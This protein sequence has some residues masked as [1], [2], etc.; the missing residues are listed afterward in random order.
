MLWQQPPRR[1]RLVL[2]DLITWMLS[3][4]D[5]ETLM[6]ET[7]GRYSVDLSPALS[8]Q[9]FLINSAV[10]LLAGCGKRVFDP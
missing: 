3:T 1:K 2:E 6:R 9:D 10:T 4:R 5:G 7:G 8:P